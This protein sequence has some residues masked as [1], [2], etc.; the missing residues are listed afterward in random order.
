ME[1]AY[2][3]EYTYC[4]AFNGLVGHGLCRLGCSNGLAKP[5]HYPTPPRP[6]GTQKPISELELKGLPHQTIESCSICLGYGFFKGIYGQIGLAY[7]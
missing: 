2:C 6:M 5:M 3:T 1:L 4:G 7:M